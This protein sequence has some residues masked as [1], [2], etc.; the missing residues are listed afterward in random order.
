METVI[1]IALIVSALLIAFLFIDIIR[2]AD[3]GT[4]K[5]VGEK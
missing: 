3:E 1:Y 4:K 2:T 5:A